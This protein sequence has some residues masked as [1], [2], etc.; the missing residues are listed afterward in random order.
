MNGCKLL[1]IEYQNTHCANQVAFWLVL[2]TSKDCM[3][4]DFKFEV[5]VGWV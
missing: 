3:R 2:K 1:D 4:R 5:R